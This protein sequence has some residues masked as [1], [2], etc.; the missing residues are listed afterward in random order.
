MGVMVPEPSTETVRSC[1][2]TAAGWYCPEEAAGL[3]KSRGRRSR[4]R[5]PAAA[6][7]RTSRLSHFL[8][9]LG[10][11]KRGA[12][13]RRS[14]VSGCT[15]ASGVSCVVSMALT[16][17]YVQLCRAPG[18][19]AGRG[20]VPSKSCLYLTA[21]GL[22]F[23]KERLKF[24]LNFARRH[25]GTPSTWGKVKEKCRSGLFQRTKRP[26][27][28]RM[29]VPGLGEAYSRQERMAWAAPSWPL[30]ATVRTAAACT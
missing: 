29:D 17:Y 16:P 26:R 5:I 3:P 18:A 25:Y 4:K 24:S 9:F 21:G 6:R 2:W 19:G 1:R 20:S 15:G 27:G 12:A 30:S 10:S 7:I 8:R 22:A 14:G 23:P 13:E 28:V 11:W